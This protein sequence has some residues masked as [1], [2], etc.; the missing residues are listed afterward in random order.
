MDCILKNEDFAREIK[1]VPDD[2]AREGIVAGGVE[3]GW[4][5]C[6]LCFKTKTHAIAQHKITTVEA[7]R[8]IIAITLP[9]SPPL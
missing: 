9:L 6:F 7:D 1:I 5:G 3:S 8:T 4:Q 2:F